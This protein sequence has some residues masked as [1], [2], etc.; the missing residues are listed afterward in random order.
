MPKKESAKDRAANKAA[1][2][3]D[4]RAKAEEDA[5]WADD[6]KSKSKKD[7]KKMDAEAKK[8]EEQQRKEERRR[9]EEEE[10]AAAATKSS[11][12]APPKKVTQFEIQQNLAAAS[13]PAKGKKKD[14]REEDD[15][16]RN[17][18]H[19]IRE[20]EENLRKAGVER[21]AASGVGEATDLLRNLSTASGGDSPDA[22][23]ER[24]R[25]AAYKAYEDREIPRMREENPGLKLSQIKEI[26]FKNWQKSPENP[27]NEGAE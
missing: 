1:E 2:A 25:K 21:H 5:L 7:S 20:T 10:A 4:A 19:V 27:I 12:A 14:V 23:P 17:I 9:L 15:I 24:R 8:L 3:A 11:K 26:I 6:S 16:D 13:A 22:H 18:N